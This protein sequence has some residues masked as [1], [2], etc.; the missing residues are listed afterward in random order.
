MWFQRAQTRA[1]KNLGFWKK[2]LGFLRFYGFFLDFSVQT[3]KTTGQKFTI[4]E[5]HPRSYHQPFSL[6]HCFVQITTNP[7]ISTKM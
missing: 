6:S 5:E 4:Q 1:G 2:F 3:T 7:Q